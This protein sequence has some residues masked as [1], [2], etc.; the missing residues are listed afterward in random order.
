MRRNSFRCYIN[1]L[2]YIFP[3]D[4]AGLGLARATAVVRVLSLDAR[5]NGYT[6]LP[7]FLGGN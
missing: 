5:L 6:L 2:N 7:F 1:D 3:E 4:Y